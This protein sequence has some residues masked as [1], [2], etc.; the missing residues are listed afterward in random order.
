MTKHKAPDHHDADLVLKLYDLRRETLMRQS[1][2]TIAKFF[3]RTF[4][5]L[6]ALTK[7]DHPSNAAWRQVSSYFEMAFSFA[8]HGIANPDFLA[9]NNGE[10]IY[11]FAKVAPHLERLRKEVS[12]AMFVN[13]EWVVNN[14]EMGKQRFDMFSQRVKTML[15]AK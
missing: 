12:P 8:R 7:P 14:S 13:S 9:E 5:D 6:L 1:R 4:D 3:P 15:A 2:D 10:G 11:L